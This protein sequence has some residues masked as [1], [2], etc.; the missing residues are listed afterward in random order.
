MVLTEDT[1]LVIK[2]TGNTN[3][4]N[5]VLMRAPQNIKLAICNIMHC[6]VYKDVTDCERHITV[7]VLW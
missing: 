5:E 2:V 1:I 4:K 7:W 6:I 3:N